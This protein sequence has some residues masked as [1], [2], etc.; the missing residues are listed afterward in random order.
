MMFNITHD[1]INHEPEATQ[2]LLLLSLHWS[3][4]NVNN[5]VHHISF[6]PRA[7]W[8]NLILNQIND[9]DHPV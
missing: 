4:Y 8:I 3:R 1:F 9:D 7:L 2:T 5:V 6:Q